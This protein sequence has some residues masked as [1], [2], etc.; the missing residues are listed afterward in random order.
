MRHLPIK[1]LF[2]FHR[3]DPFLLYNKSLNDWSLEEQ[4]ILFPSTSPRETLIFSGNKIHCS[5]QGHSLSV[6]CYI[7][8]LSLNKVNT[9]IGW[10]LVTCPWSNSNVSRPGYNCAVLARTPSSSLC[11]CYMKVY[12]YNKT[13][14]IWSRGKLVS[15]VFPPVLMFPET[16]GKHQD[17]RENKTVSLGTIH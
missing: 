10:F 12:I 7:A 13:L 16:N 15:S 1:W 9:V 3:F 5:P 4:W 14:N 8:R 11:L 6:N 17:S 2:V